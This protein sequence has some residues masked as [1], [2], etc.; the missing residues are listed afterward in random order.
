MNNS[1]HDLDPTQWAIIKDTEALRAIGHKILV[2]EDEFKSGYE[3]RSCGGT[4]HTQEKCKYCKGTTFFKADPDKGACR[5]CEV[6]TSDGRKS[7]GYTICPEC[8]GTSGVIVVP[9]TAKRRPCTGVILSKG[10]DVTEFEV[11]TRVMY[12][13]FTGTDFEVVGGTKLRIMMDYDVMAEYKRLRSSA[14]PETGAIQRELQ[15]HGIAR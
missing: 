11:G 5:D 15:D 1:D 7:L 10:K 13:N 9:D 14:S 2:L 12:T 8:K 4:G 3:C 6:G